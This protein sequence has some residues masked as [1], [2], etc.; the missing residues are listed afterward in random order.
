[1]YPKAVGAIRPAAIDAD[2]VTGLDP[3]PGRLEHDTFDP[4]LVL[5]PYSTS[6]SVTFCPLGFTLAFRVAEVWVSRVTALLLN[7]PSPPFHD[8]YRT[9]KHTP[10]LARSVWW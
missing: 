2:T 5:V 1:M 8:H 9:P 10:T 7:A 3:D 6:H 4:Y